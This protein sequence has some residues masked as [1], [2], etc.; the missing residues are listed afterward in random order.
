M[1]WKLT[2]GGVDK[3]SKVDAS[4]G[5]AI[6]MTLNERSTM[7]FTTLWTQN[8]I[9]A[10]LAEVVAYAQ[11]GTTPIFG[12][13]I[14]SREIGTV[15]SASCYATCRCSD[16]FT[17]LDWTYLDLAYTTGTTLKDV[18]TDIVAALPGSYGIT[19]DAGQVTGPT[20]EPF[21]WSQVKASDAIR[22][23]A[24]R[25]GY[26]ARMS[27]VKELEMFVLGSGA[28]PFTVEDGATHCTSIAWSDRAEPAVNSVI[29]T[30]GPSGRGDDIVQTW[31]SDG[32]ATVY[33]LAGVNVP[34][35]EEWPGSVVVGGTSYP[36]WPVGLGGAND[37]EWDYATDDGTLEF[38]GTSSALI[39]ITTTIA[40]RYVPQYP[41]TV[42]AASGGTPVV[43][44]L[45]SYPAV[46]VYDQADEIAAG[47]LA[48]VNQSPR[49]LT[50]TSLDYGT[51]EPG[52][53]L[54]VD[55]AAVSVTATCLIT[56]V[57]I[58]LIASGFWEYG[59]RATESATYGGDYRQGWR[60]IIQGGGSVTSVTI[61]GS[62]GGS[63]TRW[64]IW[65]GG[66]DL[67]SA[68]MD[69]VTPV[70]VRMVSS[71]TMTAQAT[72]AW[73]LRAWLWS[74]ASG[75]TM[76]ARVYC[77]TDAGEVGNVSGVTGTTHPASP[78]KSAA[79]MVEAGKDYRIDVYGDV[80][81][82]GVYGFAELYPVG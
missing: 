17:Y 23:L 6:D 18:L 74:R 66:S 76:S 59:L 16:F 68:P 52:Q 43:Q 27:P 54:T 13:V 44:G 72:E 56:S 67:A 79:F 4:A 57:A 65:M 37:I 20:L 77:V 73:V 48:E 47:L 53:S 38:K 40:L 29:L 41:F 9:P 60:D 61:G 10:R 49:E 22:E 55:V 50:L 64:P 32:V 45:Y 62:S 42:T 3:T 8:Y 81:G 5:C 31:V 78:T 75:V 33:A 58:N 35:S 2:I 80:A 70:Y 30:C 1:A 24:T 15:G 69:A 11:D 82:S 12:G 21:T 34:A 19:L 63:S 28:S 26:A 71:R 39:P 46:V 7:T 36:I 25:T 51:W 14:L